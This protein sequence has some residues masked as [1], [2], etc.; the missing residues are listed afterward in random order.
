VR[1]SAKLYERRR[2]LAEAFHYK[3]YRLVGPIER[4]IA[5]D[6]QRRYCGT[7]IGVTGSCGKSTTSH[8][9]ATLLADYG[10]VGRG[11]LVNIGRA[12]FRTLRHLKRPTDY[13]VQEIS[14][15]GGP[16][17]VAAIVGQ[18]R[19]DVAVITSVNKEHR[20]AYP[21][22][23]AIAYEK[24]QLARAVRP[25]GLSL[26]NADDR[27]V[28]AMAPDVGGRVL[29]FG[30]SPDADIRAENIAAHWPHRMSFDLVVGQAR[31]RVTTRFVGT[32]MLTNVLAAL[33]VLH[34]LGL[35]LAP[36]IARLA[37]IEPIYEHM[38]IHEG[39]D[40]K[41]YVLDT[42]K[43]PLWSTERLINDL[44]NFAAPGTVL[45]LAQL[46]DTYGNPS[47][48]YRKLL[49]SA[50][51]SVDHVIALGM[52]ARQGVKVQAEGVTNLTCLTSF[53]AV[54]E[55]LKTLPPCLV[56]IKSA[57]VLKLSRIFL[58][59]ETEVRCRKLACGMHV[60]CVACKLLGEETG[61][62]RRRMTP[63]QP[64][65]EAAEGG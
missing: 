11:S 8:L 62:G 29:L 37:G 59:G 20:A 47:Q 23:E 45:V 64:L 54:V 24:S 50:A 1:L 31:H 25:G 2:I 51:G 4:A 49:R 52:A 48:W 14:G 16:G 6:R 65:P 41:T 33:G 19:I 44:P 39:R 17:S 7:Y 34:G 3:W 61:R 43:A 40:G 10:S 55:H 57:E 30:T 18:L 27:L 38:S 63:Q 13:V 32:L 42:I 36:A 9:L 28:R 56:V 35:D 53:E 26:L 12:V 60:D 46:S 15:H 22:V 21:D 58:A 5:R